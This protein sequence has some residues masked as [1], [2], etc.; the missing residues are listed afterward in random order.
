MLVYDFFTMR[1]YFIN[2]TRRHDGHE[3]KP[4][5]IW[6]LPHGKDTKEKK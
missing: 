6:A 2:E 3:E 5:K 4:K 1:W